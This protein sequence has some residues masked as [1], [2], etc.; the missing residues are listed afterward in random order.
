MKRLSGGLMVAV[1]V[2]WLVASPACTPAEL[3]ASIPGD[4]EIQ[5]SWGS[6]HGGWGRYELTINAKGEAN[7]EKSYV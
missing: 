5:Y 3:P 7:F 4:L 6:C 2:S 1:L